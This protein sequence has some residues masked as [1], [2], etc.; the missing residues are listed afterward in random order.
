[1]GRSGWVKVSWQK[2]VKD[3]EV[4]VEVVR[5]ANGEVKPIIGDWNRIKDRKVWLKVRYYPN[6][7][8]NLL[9]TLLTVDAIKRIG[10][11][12][13][14][15]EALWFPYSPQDRVFV[16]GEPLSMELVVRLLEKAGVDEFVVWELHKIE[17]LKFFTKPVIHKSFIPLFVKQLKA[18]IDK[19]WVV[20]SPDVG[21]KERAKEVARLLGLKWGYWEKERNRQT[22]K[23]KF[24]RLK[25]VDVMGKNIIL[26]DDFSAKG[27]T[28]LSSAKKLKEKGAKQVLVC[29]GYWLM[30]KERL[31]QL[32]RSKWIDEIVEI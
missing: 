30:E 4:N 22:G 9:L 12:K 13:I 20:V 3:K 23:I 7:N 27:G 29:M 5:F 14:R 31:E 10:V 32:K 26:V 17:S 2:A 11:K 16:K 25:R 8:H 18:R 24:G 6:V 19:G 1:M 15:L 21:G 28:I